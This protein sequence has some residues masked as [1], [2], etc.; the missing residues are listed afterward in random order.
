[1]G[2]DCVSLAASSSCY[3]VRLM[4]GL[5]STSRGWNK[6]GPGNLNNSML[7]KFFCPCLSNGADYS[8]CQY[9]KVF[10]VC[11]NTAL[12]N[13]A[14]TLKT[15]WGFVCVL[16]SWVETGFVLRKWEAAKQGEVGWKSRTRMMGKSTQGD[17]TPAAACDTPSGIMDHVAP[18]WRPRAADYCSLY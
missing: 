14:C 7:V 16:K 13:S 3:D 12:R 9:L 10:K 11:L 2:T 5:E 17:E 15:S 8:V 1:M 18:G 6:W 4:H